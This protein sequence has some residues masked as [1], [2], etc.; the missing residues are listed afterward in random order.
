MMEA[1]LSNHFTSL[2]CHLSNEELS[3]VEGLS[4]LSLIDK[5][6]AVDDRW[7]L[8]WTI[9]SDHFEHPQTDKSEKVLFL[10]YI[11]KR[12]S[13]WVFT[14]EHLNFDTEMRLH[15]VCSA[16]EFSVDKSTP[17]YP[18]N[19]V[20][21]GVVAVPKLV[22]ASWSMSFPTCLAG[23]GATLNGSTVFYR[24]STKF[25][26]NKDITNEDSSAMFT[27]LIGTKADDLFYFIDNGL[28]DLN[29]IKQSN[30]GS[31]EDESL[32][33]PSGPS[34]GPGVGLSYYRDVLPTHVVPHN[35]PGRGSFYLDKCF[36]DGFLSRL[37]CLWKTLPE[38]PPE[39]ET[40]SKRYYCCDSFGWVREGIENVVMKYVLQCEGSM[41]ISNEGKNSGRNGNHGLVGRKHYF[42][43][44]AFMRFLYY[45]VD[46][47]D[48]PPHID[49]SKRELQCQSNGQDTTAVSSTH[50][51]ILYLSDCESAG[52][53]ALLLDLKPQKSD[54]REAPMVEGESSVDVEESGKSQHALSPVVLA[55]VVPK[56]GRLLVF[57]H[58]CPHSGLPINSCHKLLLRGELTLS[59]KLQ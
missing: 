13:A 15:V 8:L 9:F 24:D 43:P 45:D 36:S 27:R 34:G 22:Y 29:A 21:V 31:E 32:P 6:L 35:H 58:S 46:G 59:H 48:L 30:G 37:T 10:D 53:T 5:P 47:G 54:E 20:S 3:T 57:P 26:C 38:T 11:S 17:E 51:F 19:E 50:T 2:H 39:K 40:C 23:P 41:D 16:T 49:L 1:Y 52:E 12:S 55:G 25:L 42:Y 14:H 33:G 7:S 56:R 44:H 4:P 28:N 18:S